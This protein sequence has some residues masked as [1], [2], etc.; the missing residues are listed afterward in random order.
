MVDARLTNCAD[1]AK[2]IVRASPDGPVARRLTVRH[3][4]ATWSASARVLTVG[5]KP[6]SWLL[7]SADEPSAAIV[8]HT[9]ALVDGEFAS[10]VDVTH[11]HWLGRLTGDGSTRSLAAVCAID[12]ADSATTNGRALRTRIAAVT[13]TVIRDDDAGARSYLVLCDRSYGHYLVSVLACD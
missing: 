8:R 12:L 5:W 3:G 10:V 1:W 2:V 13:A 9:E 4:R 6:D 7:L 11:G